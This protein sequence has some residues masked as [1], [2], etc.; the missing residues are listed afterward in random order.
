MA[1]IDPRMVQSPKGR[2]EDLVVIHD[3]G[4]HSY[5]VARM[6]WDKDPGAIGV[7]WN[8]GEGQGVGNP[9]SRGVA[10]WFILPEPIAKM[11]EANPSSL[12]DSQT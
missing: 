5:S 12:G 11:V 1:Y 4:E 2:V 7:R 6:T 8:G 10:T 3:G 9:Q